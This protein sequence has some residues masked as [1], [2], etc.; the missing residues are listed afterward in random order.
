MAPTPSSFVAS[1]VSLVAAT[2]L[3]AA[4]LLA[5]PGHTATPAHVHAAWGAVDV[6]AWAVIGVA[7]AYVVIN[8]MMAKT[9]R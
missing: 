7:F 4:D 2:L 6:G 5:H 8:L 9:R 1:T 3:P